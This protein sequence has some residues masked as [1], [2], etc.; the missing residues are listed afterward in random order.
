MTVM[1]NSGPAPTLAPRPA[2]AEPAPASSKKG[3]KGKGDA[4][5]E[6]APK[7]SKA[8][9]FIILFVVLALVGFK[10]K[11]LFIKPHYTTAHPA[12]AGAIYPL[13]NTSPFTITTTDGHTVETNVALQLTS[14]AS[15][16]K[17]AKDEPAIENIV[18]TVLGNMTYGELLPESGRQTAAA[19]ILQEIQK[20]LGPVEGSPQVTQVLFTGSFVLQ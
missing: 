14:V 15:A 9:L 7:K 6:E 5:G 20:L 12:P 4:E 18:I 19:Q 13:A 11:S 16:K 2:A 8:K 10:E 1:P 17:L 3:A